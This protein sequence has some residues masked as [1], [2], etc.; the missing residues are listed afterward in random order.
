MELYINILKITRFK[1]RDADEKAM[2]MN[3]LKLN[4][5]LTLR[6]DLRGFRQSLTW[7]FKI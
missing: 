7:G 1:K 4:S 2:R 3:F 5:E 6:S